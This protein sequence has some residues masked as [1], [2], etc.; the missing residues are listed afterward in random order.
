M[1]VTPISG[2]PRRGV[3]VIAEALLECGVEGTQA[4]PV[5][6]GLRAHVAAALIKGDVE[7]VAVRQRF[8]PAALAQLGLVNGQALHEVALVVIPFGLGLG[9]DLPC[10]T[11]GAGET[12]ASQ[13]ALDG[14]GFPSVESL[15]ADSEFSGEA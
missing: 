1:D 15:G 9:D 11:D 7:G 10:L 14:S 13:A 6:F 3:G 8:M 4:A 5:T 12:V 2:A